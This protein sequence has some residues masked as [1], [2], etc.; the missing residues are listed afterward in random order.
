MITIVYIFFFLVL[1]YIF[2]VD[3]KEREITLYSL[4]ALTFTGGVLALEQH[5]VEW[6]GQFWI[7]NIIFIGVQ[8]GLLTLYL[9]LRYKEGKLIFIKWIGLGDLLFFISVSI[10]YSFDE[11]ALVYLGSLL[12]S[13]I[14]FICFKSRLK[15]IP[16][17]GFSA[18]FILFF[19]I[20]KML[21]P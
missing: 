4:L 21:I 15:T 5:P 8:Y 7:L 6:V 10:Y 12:F 20:Y 2:Y 1:A 3:V 17:A 19:E 13:A 18:L 11:F 16:L 14:L 9:E